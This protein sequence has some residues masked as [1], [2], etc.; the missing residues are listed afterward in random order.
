LDFTHPLIG[1]Q[2][3]V[4]CAGNVIEIWQDAIG[5]LFFAG[6]PRQLIE[7]DQD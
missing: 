1:Y 3:T 7:M 6:V 5:R 2:R 4:Y